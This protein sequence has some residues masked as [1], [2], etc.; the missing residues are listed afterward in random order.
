[1]AKSLVGGNIATEIGVH[2]QKVYKCKSSVE[3]AGIMVCVMF[4]YVLMGGVRKQ[5]FD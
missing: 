4:A 2:L 1:M 5:M 3:I